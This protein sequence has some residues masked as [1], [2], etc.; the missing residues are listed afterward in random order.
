MQDLCPRLRVTVPD[1][2]CSIQTAGDHRALVGGKEDGR[3]LS[4]VASV[5]AFWLPGGNFPKPDGCVA[6]SGQKESSIPREPERGDL[7]ARIHDPPPCLAPRRV[8]DNHPAIVCPS[9]EGTS[10]RRK[11]TG[12]HPP[13]MLKWKRRSHAGS[14]IPQEG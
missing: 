14:D 9:D 6:R 2:D 11:L 1:F 3:H 4:L 8:P 12:L 5:N 13:L 7:P 10:V